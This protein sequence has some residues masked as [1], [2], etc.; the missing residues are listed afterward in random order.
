MSFIET[1]G[2]KQREF[3]PIGPIS[4]AL[5]FF[6]NLRLHPIP[7]KCPTEIVDIHVLYPALAIGNGGAYTS[8]FNPKKADPA[9]KQNSPTAPMKASDVKAGYVLFTVDGNGKN[10]YRCSETLG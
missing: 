4:P 1:A 10:N 7:P 5:D 6:N 8:G 2:T 3:R 9:V